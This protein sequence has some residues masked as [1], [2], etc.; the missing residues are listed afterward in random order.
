MGSKKKGRWRELKEMKHFGRVLRLVWPHKKYLIMAMIATMGT[1]LCYTASI[2]SLYPLLK[3]MVEKE[4]IHDFVDRLYLENRLGLTLSTYETTNLSIDKQ[5]GP[6]A[7]QIVEVKSIKTNSLYE[8]GV[9]KLDFI[10]DADGKGL[11]G[12]ELVRYLADV[13]T[14]DDVRLTIFSPNQSAERFA[15]ATPKKP[16]WDYSIL[17]WAASYVPKETAGT[18]EMT[19]E[20]FLQS[21]LRMLKYILIGL[22]FVNIVGNICRFIGQY[23]GSVV[24]ARTLMDL[25]RLMYAKALMQPMSI[26]VS[27][28]VSDTMS[29]FVKDTYDILSALSTLFGKVLREPLKAIGVLVGALYLEPR[30]TL[31]LLIIGPITMVLFRKFGRRIRRSSEKMLEGYS[32]LVGALECTLSGI[33]VVKAYTMEHRERKRYFKVERNILNHQLRISMVKA[34]SSPILEVL[35][36]AAVFGGMLWMMSVMINEQMDL[37]TS[38]LFTLVF[39]MV[40]LADPVRKLSDVYTEVQ[41]ANA[42]SKRVF[43]LIDRPTE[44]DLRQG[45][46]KALAPKSGITFENVRFT[47][48]NSN[49]PALDG[50]DMEVKAGQVV[51][52]VGPNGSGKTTLISLLMR[53]FDP[54]EGRILWDGVDLTEFQ[55]RS[56]RRKISYVAQETVIFAD[57]MRNNIAYGNP[58]ASLEQ[59]QHAARQAHA[60]EF[61]D[62]LPNGYDT[63]A[64]ERGMTLSG[65]ERQRLAIAR[66]ILR[67]A[68]VLIMDE[69]TSQIDADSE[70]KIQDAINRFMPGRTAIVIA[71]RFSTIARADVV[72]VMD[73]GKIVASGSHQ[74]LMTTS[75]LYHTLYQT[76]LQGLTKS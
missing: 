47:Y 17:R 1:A 8:K 23:L 13:K 53:M 2:A 70:A 38:K 60:D 74:S 58:S 33:K 34:M 28:G 11:T 46:R 49:R 64:G 36:L 22:L 30:I 24:A 40:A 14:G 15:V 69:A 12:L 20:T 54:Q 62:R 19:Q 63:I 55:L 48:P 35:G 16:K 45:P 32:Q 65:G 56:L 6:V 61:I 31:L 50:V 57:S 3:V 29:R 68:P 75:S 5:V 21:R 52:V 71:H 42:A 73:Y 72:V 67:D 76:Q 4:T 7:V 27:H 43:E 25:R 18:T 37:D 51:A 39:A 66:A 44:F 10:V 41:Q 9:R 59:I 26:Y